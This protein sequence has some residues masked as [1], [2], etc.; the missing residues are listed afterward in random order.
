M[1]T[2]TRRQG[3]P[4]TLP[5]H[6]VREICDNASSRADNRDEMRKEVALEDICSVPR[7][8]NC[9]PS[10]RLTRPPKDIRG[11]NACIFH[12]QWH[13]AWREKAA[14][15]AMHHQGGTKA[16]RTRPSTSASS[17]EY[18]VFSAERKKKGHTMVNRFQEAPLQTN[19]VLELTA[20][21]GRR[22]LCIKEGWC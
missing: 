19:K 4:P 10:R 22:Y 8:H 3:N 9:T 7:W 16:W 15:T 12:T 6:A 1:A 11:P 13:L 17:K 2:L 20:H 21:V 18:I 14:A 5:T